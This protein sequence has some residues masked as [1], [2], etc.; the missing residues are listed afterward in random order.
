[1]DESGKQGGKGAFIQN[2]DKR[3]PDLI[4]SHHRRKAVLFLVSVVRTLNLTV[5]S[6]VEWEI[7]L[8]VFVP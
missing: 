2:C 4:A 7:W 1:M 5:Q 6:S 8:R 3:L